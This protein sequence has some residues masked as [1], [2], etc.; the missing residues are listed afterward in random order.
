M[1]DTVLRCKNC[2]TTVSPIEINCEHCGFPLAGNAEEKLLFLKKQRRNKSLIQATEKF[3]RRSSFVLYVIGIFH[4][5][6]AF[7][8]FKRDY[9]IEVVAISIFIGLIFF[10]FGFFMPKHPVL[11]SALSLGLLLVIYITDYLVNQNTLTKGLIW[12]LAIIT[13]LVFTLINAIQVH[14]IKK[15]NKFLH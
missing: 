9:S 6:S 12:K 3:Q 14:F 13:T 5:Y 4:L 7:L 15:K 1:S 11:F 8:Y 2:K 10:V